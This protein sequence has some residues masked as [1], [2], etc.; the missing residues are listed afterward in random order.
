MLANGKKNH[1]MPTRIKHAY[2]YRQGN[3]GV[4]QQKAWLTKACLHRASDFS[5]RQTT[6]AMKH[7][8]LFYASAMASGHFLAD[9]RRGLAALVVA[10]AHHSSIVKFGHSASP[11]SSNKTL[12]EI[13]SGVPTSALS[14]TI[15][16]DISCGLSI[17]IMACAHRLAILRRGCT[18]CLCVC[19]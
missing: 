12:N 9:V 19:T 7:W 2:S 18:H 11:L 8:S 4:S 3:I 15:L 14:Y 1:P 17:S 16:V 5:K 6:S 13:W 10:Y